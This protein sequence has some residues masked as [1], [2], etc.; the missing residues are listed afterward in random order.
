[1]LVYLV[2]V[3]PFTEPHISAINVYN[4]IVLLISFTAVLL[5]NV[6]E[7][8]DSTINN[9]G[10]ALIALIL[11]SLISLWVVTA[12]EVYKAVR[13]FLRRLQRKRPKSPKS[14]RR[15]KNKNSK[16]AANHANRLGNRISPT[17]RNAK[18]SSCK[19]A[20][21]KIVK[22]EKPRVNAP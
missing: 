3:R 16:S 21:M 8:S 20:R 19:K 15:S 18:D 5:M 6:Q 7:L 14:L 22:T 13:E 9:I 12:P 11:I 17:H 10:W 4:E 2:A 1:M